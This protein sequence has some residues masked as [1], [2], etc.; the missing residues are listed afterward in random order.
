MRYK[1]NSGELGWEGM[2]RA[3]AGARVIMKA[4]IKVLRPLTKS[5]PHSRAQSQY[6]YEVP[7]PL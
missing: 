5:Q 4:T 1:Q 2:E 7:P 6:S 3:I